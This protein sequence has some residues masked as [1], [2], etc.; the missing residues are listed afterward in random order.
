V[1]AA[2]DFIDARLQYESA[3]ERAQS[4]SERLGGG[5]N[6]Y[7]ASVGAVRGTI[8]DAARRYSGLT[9]DD[10]TALSSELWL[11]PVFERRLAAI[12]LLQLNVSI[13]VGTDLTRL[14]GF[15]RDARMAELADPL[16]RDVIIP[17]LQGMDATARA[18]AAVVIRR[19][20]S[21]DNVCL[22]K[23]AEVLRND[24]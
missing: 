15:L 1:T 14:E 5:L 11:V 2:C 7:G 18:R 24:S 19:W 22:R 10:I 20:A 23:A 13:L 6:Y 3:A 16:T 12:V 17:L 8:R 4:D 9:H 21:D